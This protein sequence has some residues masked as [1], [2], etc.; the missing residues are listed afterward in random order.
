M[1]SRTHTVEISARGRAVKVTFRE[2]SAQAELLRRL[3][4][5]RIAAI[6]DERQQAIA[7][8]ASALDVATDIVVALDGVP[9]RSEVRETLDRLGV[10]F[11]GSLL[12]AYRTATTVSDDTVGKSEGGHD[13]TA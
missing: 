5:A 8:V 3:D 4:A 6:T 1:I 13:A 12:L 9:L 7:Y 11:L 10:D 2:M